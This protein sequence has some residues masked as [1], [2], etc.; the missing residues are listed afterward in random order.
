MSCRAWALA[1]ARSAARSDTII[2]FL[3]YKKNV[4]TYIYN[5]Y[6]I[7]KTFKHD[8]LLVR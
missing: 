6:S 7:L 3:F 2:F 1:S 5:L 4:Y 8:I